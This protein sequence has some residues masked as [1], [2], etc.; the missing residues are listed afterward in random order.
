MALALLPEVSA[1]AYK[2]NWSHSN[3]NLSITGEDTS[4]ATITGNMLFHNSRLITHNTD[5]CIDFPLS[6]L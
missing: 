1:A 2:M 5:S 6:L 3:T 4:T